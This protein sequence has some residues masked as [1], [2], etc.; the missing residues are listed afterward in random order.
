MTDGVVVWAEV[1][2][3]EPLIA[4]PI[5]TIRATAVLVVEALGRIVLTA[6]VSAPAVAVQDALGRV[7]ELD[8]SPATVIPFALA[9]AL[10][11]GSVI[12]M[13]GVGTSTSLVAVA[14]ESVKLEVTA[15]APADEVQEA[16]G[17]TKF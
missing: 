15:N 13:V 14:L 1:L 7:K 8:E 17:R 2:T 16:A 10:E 4:G 3:L 5:T 12:P 9:V 11:A 6:K